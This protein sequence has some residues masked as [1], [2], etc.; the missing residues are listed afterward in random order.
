MKMQCLLLRI[1]PSIS[2]LS[3]SG[4]FVQ[5]ANKSLSFFEG[6]GKRHLFISYSPEL[7]VHLHTM[8]STWN[9]VCS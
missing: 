6:L 4:L 9:Y 8:K 3:V 1:L 5:V 7:L 2:H